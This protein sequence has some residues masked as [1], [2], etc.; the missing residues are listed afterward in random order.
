MTR[1]SSS[2]RKLSAAILDYDAERDR[3]KWQAKPRAHKRQAV[4][5][6]IVGES[7]VLV[8]KLPTFLTV[9]CACGNS[10]RVWFH[11]KRPRY[12]CSQCGRL[13]L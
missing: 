11:G 1:P 12:R 8:R 6:R 3:E 13:A 4:L 10:K 7:D 9:R 5:N 2:K